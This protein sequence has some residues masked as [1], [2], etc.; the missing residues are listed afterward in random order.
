MQSLEATQNR[1]RSVGA[2]IPYCSA[3]TPWK[4]IAFVLCVDT[5]WM[6]LGGWSVNGRSIGLVLLVLTACMFPLAFPRYRDDPRVRNTLQATAQFI[7]FL[8]TASTL[9]YLII[10]TNAPLVDGTLHAWDVSLG[11]DWLAFH[12]W[13]RRHPALATTLHYVYQS[14]LIQLVLVILFLG[15]SGRAERLESFMRLYIVTALMTIVVS[16]LMPAAGAWK[17]YELIGTFPLE[18][19]SH[20]EPLRDGRMRNIPMGGQM[21]GLVSIPSFHAATAV[22]LIHAMRGIRLLMPIFAL[23]NAAMLVSTPIDGSHFFVDVVAGVVMAMALIALDKFR[24]ARPQ[25]HPSNTDIPQLS[26]LRR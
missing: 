25:T 2:S 14:G 8:A 23:L 18:A 5:V 6:V 1:S 22:L 17:Y 7:A 12:A 16:A 10:S 24:S 20:F 21:Q 19:L 11:F 15:F 3:C 9:S 4:F 13:L 26:A